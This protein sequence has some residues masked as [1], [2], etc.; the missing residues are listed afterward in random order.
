MIHTIFPKTIWMA[1]NILVDELPSLSQFCVDIC[2][3]YSVESNDLLNVPSTHK[4]ES[5]LQQFPEMQ[6][7]VK[8]I[9]I[10]A[11]EYCKELGYSNTDIEDMSLHNMWTNVSGEN[12][13]IFPH[14]HR[15][16]FISGVYY[17]ECNPDDEI[18]FFNNPNDLMDRKP[19]TSNTFNSEYYTIPCLP[20]RLIMFKSNMLHGTQSQKS[21]RKIA[22]SFNLR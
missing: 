17:V 15:D 19:T 3:T 14:N 1:D 20:G 11:L 12:S 2:D 4:T 13:Y 7:L 10:N 16:S 5:N 6:S 22:I 8:H 18:T 21:H 9:C